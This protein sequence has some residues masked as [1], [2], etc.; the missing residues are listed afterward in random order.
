VTRDS[1][2]L[3]TIAKQLMDAETSGMTSAEVDGLSTFRVVDELR[4]HLSM[5]MG[6]GGFQALLARALVLARADVSWLSRLR[7]IADGDL[8]GLTD[9]RSTIDA[10]DFREGEIAVLVR[11]L[12]LLVAFIGPAL[13]LRLIN[14]LWPQ[15][16]FK[17]AD[18]GKMANCG[19]AK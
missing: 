14:Q 16:S 15:L 18:F 10:A 12:G 11:L 17:D 6:R 9:A 3:R 19:E 2:Q 4:P 13:T 7:S 8:D 5:L 1:S